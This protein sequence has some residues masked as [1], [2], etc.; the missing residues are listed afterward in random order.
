[1]VAFDVA[2]PSGVFHRR[3]V[4]P[5]GDRYKFV[6]GDISDLEQLL[7]AASANKVDR[8]VN[9]AMILSKDPYPAREHQDRR[10]RHVQRVRGGPPARHQ[11]GG[12]RQLRDGLRRAEGLRRPRDQSR[13]TGC[14]PSPA[15]STLWPSAWPRSSPS[16]YDELYG[17][18][19]TALRPTIGYGH[20]GKNP[21]FVR[22]FSDIVSL[23]AIGQAGPPR[24][25]RRLALLAGQVRRRGRVR[26]SGAQGPVVAAP[27]LQPGRAAVTLKD[28]AAVVKKY[29]PDAQIT[30][31][32]EP[33][34]CELPWKVSCDLA[35][36]DFGF[37]VT[38]LEEAVLS[39][40]QRGAGRRPAWSRWH[41]RSGQ[42]L[43]EAHGAGHDRPGDDPQPHHQDGQR[44]LVSW[45]RTRPSARA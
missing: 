16:Q 35:K 37:T 20:G 13:T 38:P 28:V 39:P 30:F 21:K 15:A 3:R 14:C 41:E 23:P 6:R 32:D 45:S 11:A 7:A 42:A 25:H 8:M 9:W 10:A 24:V 44:H 17:V 5:Y 43:R 34:D 36:Q 22:W 1:M 12:L 33:E 31:G 18:K 26:P 40:H 27:G 4:E 2:P 19:P 29:I